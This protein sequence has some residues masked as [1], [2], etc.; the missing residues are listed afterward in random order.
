MGN[1]VKFVA[2][3]GSVPRR[4]QVNGG[5]MQTCQIIILPCVR[6]ERTSEVGSKPTPQKKK[7][8]KRRVRSR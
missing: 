1:I 4:A 7:K 2:R 8:A 6:Y 5:L 3:T